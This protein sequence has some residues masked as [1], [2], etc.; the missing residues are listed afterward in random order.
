MSCEPLIQAKALFKTNYDF[1]KIMIPSSISSYGPSPS[2]FRVF[3]T[4]VITSEATFVML[5]ILMFSH[6]LACSRFVHICSH[7]EQACFLY[8]LADFGKSVAVQQI[9]RIV[10]AMN[11]PCT[12]SYYLD[13]S[14]FI[15]RI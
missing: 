10:S 3:F 6:V 4:A 5:A 1:I 7:P 15:F 13:L 9:L 2:N 12:F 11:S 8:Y 14:N